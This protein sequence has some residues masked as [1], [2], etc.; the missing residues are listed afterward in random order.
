V[1]PLRKYMSQFLGNPVI[2]LFPKISQ[3]DALSMCCKPF[4]CYC[5][6]GIA[7]QLSLC[8]PDS[9]IIPFVYF[10]VIAFLAHR[11]KEQ[12]LICPLSS[13]LSLIKKTPLF[14]I[15]LSITYPSA[16]FYQI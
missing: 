11:K 13:E 16:V 6:S 1:N 14:M 8:H 5:N 12:I 15:R 3:V 2:S 9:F 4:T 10:S 7:R